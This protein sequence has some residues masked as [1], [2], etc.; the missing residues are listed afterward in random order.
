[1]S[2][3]S[4][5]E[6]GKKQAPA[7]LEKLYDILVSPTYVDFIAWQ[8]DGQSFLIKKVED[9][10]RIVLPQVAPTSPYAST[11]SCLREP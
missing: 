10:S 2:E 3:T 11:A 4:G 6:G 5:P 1:M 7:F 9:F 8:P